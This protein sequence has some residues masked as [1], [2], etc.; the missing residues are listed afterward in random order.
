[1]SLPFGLAPFGIW[2]VTLASIVAL[3]YCLKRLGLLHSLGVLLVFS[4]GK[5]AVGTSWIYEAL[6]T[7]GDISPLMSIVL[8]CAFVAFYALFFTLTVFLVRIAIDRFLVPLLKPHDEIVDSLGWC[9]GWL[10]FEQIN[11]LTGVDTSFPWLHIGYA[12]TDTW[13]AGLASI[14]GVTL[15][16]AVV[17]AI[18][19]GILLLPRMR[20]VSLVVIGAPWLGGLLSLQ[21]DWTKPSSEIDVALVQANIT[22]PEKMAEDGFSRSW[23]AHAELTAQVAEADLV[24]WPEG[25]LPRYEDEVRLYFRRLAVQYDTRLLAGA[26]VRR[27]GS[28][29]EETVRVYNGL[30]G[31]EPHDREVHTFLKTKLVPFGEY[32][33]FSWLFEPIRE[34][35]DIEYSDLTRGSILQPPLEFASWTIGVS[36][37]YEIAFPYLIANRAK[38]T[39]FIV[40]G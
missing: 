29:E 27:N 40:A 2:P 5:F 36:I 16:S 8:V 31:F 12:F 14:G 26:Y 24:I 25:A 19:L 32:T 11:Y 7:L 4:L 21:T 33:P 37:C 28:F 39:D 38:A 15:V 17:L 13:L 30:V 18:A 22:L 20:L 34:M 10:V 23:L 1:M 9:V 35:L 6:I 3:L